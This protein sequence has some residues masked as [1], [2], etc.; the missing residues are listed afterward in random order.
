MTSASSRE[1][2]PS[3]YSMI[4]VVLARPIQFSKNRPDPYR[5]PGP[6]SALHPFRR[7]PIHGRDRFLGNLTSL[8]SQPGPVNPHPSPAASAQRLPGE[9]RCTRKRG[10]G[11]RRLRF[12][13]LAFRVQLGVPEEAGP[14]WG[15]ASKAKLDNTR[16]GRACQPL[17]VVDARGLSHHPLRRPR[18]LTRFHVTLP[19]IRQVKAT[20]TGTILR[21]GRNAV[22]SHRA[23]GL[24]RRAEG[25]TGLRF[26]AKALKAGSA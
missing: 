13:R 26:K 3:L 20:R 23:S 16:Q 14:T 11:I 9:H 21:D 6:G 4:R 1:L 10:D 25:P 8:P 22:N 7:V 24:T 18:T 17:S 15:R 19:H 12:E 5:Q 2:D